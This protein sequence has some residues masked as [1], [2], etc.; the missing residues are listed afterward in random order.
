M[1]VHGRVR[2]R[3]REI[4]SLKPELLKPGRV[5]QRI[6]HCFGEAG[7]IGGLEQ[8]AGPALLDQ[9]EP[10]TSERVRWAAAWMHARGE[11]NRA[12]E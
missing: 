11:R 10:V 7:G 2:S 3:R 8:C 6:L 9:L 12:C 1:P 5:G 4:E